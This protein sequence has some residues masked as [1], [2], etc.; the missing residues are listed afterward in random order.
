[1]GER[2][3]V[4]SIGERCVVAAWADTGRGTGRTRPEWGIRRN[5]SG[6]ADGRG[7]SVADLLSGK[8]ELSG[9]KSK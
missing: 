3:R 5:E 2:R 6:M 1:M 4:V 7:K 9:S 8:G